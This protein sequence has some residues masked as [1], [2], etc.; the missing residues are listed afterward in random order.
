MV[1]VTQCGVWSLDSKLNCSETEYS[2]TVCIWINL[3]KVELKIKGMMS[4]RRQ[5]RKY[6]TLLSNKYSKSTIICGQIPFVRNSESSWDSHVPNVSAKPAPLKLVG[7][8]KTLSYH[9]PYPWH[10]AIL[11]EGNSQIPVP[12]WWGK[13]VDHISKVPAFPEA[14]W[15]TGY[16]LACLRRLTGPGMLYMPGGC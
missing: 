14:S 12:P 4:A 11:S 8:F 16:C 15:G 7:I 3:K 13:E 2:R 9:N 1:I 10:H 5:N 6:W